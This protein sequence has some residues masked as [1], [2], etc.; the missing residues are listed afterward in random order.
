MFFSGSRASGCDRTEHRDRTW[1]MYDT[2]TR[3]YDVIEYFD[4]LTRGMARGDT[5]LMD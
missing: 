3:Y 5:W 1:R 4:A 2:K